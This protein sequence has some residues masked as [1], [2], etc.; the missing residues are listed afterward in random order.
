MRR[1]GPRPLSAA[2]GAATTAMAPATLLARVQA[3]WPEVAGEVLV[4]EAQPVS[5][6]AGEVRVACRSATWAHELE[7]MAEDLRGRLNGALG[8]PSSGPVKA[9]RFRPGGMPGSASAGDP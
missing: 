8:A 3:V 6:R 2:L 1:P 4:E 9:L 7:L 5:E